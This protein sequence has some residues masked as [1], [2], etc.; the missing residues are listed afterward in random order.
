MMSRVIR[1][2]GGLFMQV[3]PNFHF[4]GNCSEAI[5]LYKK[6]MGLE[7]TKLITNEM[8]NDDISEE[9]FKKQVFH[10]EARLFGSRIFMTDVDDKSYII[11]CNPL[12]LTITFDSAVKVREVYNL[13]KANSKTIAPFQSTS[14]ASA[15]VSF[16]DR[17]GMRWELM[18]EKTIR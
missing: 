2:I 17:Y 9:N 15:F 14:Y 10:A 4:K 13:M 18:T 8:V 7:V 11:N 16:I 12:S 5:D 6:A 1:F 3:T